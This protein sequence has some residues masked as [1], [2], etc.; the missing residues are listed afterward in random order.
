MKKS[1]II[2]IVLFIILFVVFFSLAAYAFVNFTV[3]WASLSTEI[4]FILAIFK[5]SF[6]EFFF[7]TPVM[8]YITRLLIGIV[9]F[10]WFLGLL[11]NV[12]RVFK[13]DYFRGDR[14]KLFD[15]MDKK[16]EFKRKTTTNYKN[17]INQLNRG[18][19]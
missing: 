14:K 16:A 11:F 6:S 3:L 13:F 1:S 2:V 10:K 18:F 12:D 7:G 9:A 15:K 5:Y 4:S 17:Y 19:L 8:K